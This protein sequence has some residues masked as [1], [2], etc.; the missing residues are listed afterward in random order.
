MWVIYIGQLMQSLGLVRPMNTEVAPSKL[1]RLLYWCFVIAAK[2]VSELWIIPPHV[3]RA[4]VMWLTNASSIC[5]GRTTA[6]DEYVGCDHLARAIETDDV[7][8]VLRLINKYP[9]II[10]KSWLGSTPLEL[11]V[12]TCALS[13]MEVLLACSD[14][15]A[16]EVLR[17]CHSVLAYQKLVAKGADPN[18]R[19]K[20][21]RRCVDVVALNEC[22]DV[23][24][25]MIRE[26]ARP[27]PTCFKV[28]RSRGQDDVAEKL[29][30]LIFEITLERRKFVSLLL[31]RS[32]DRLY[33]SSLVRD[34]I[35]EYLDV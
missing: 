2:A 8:Q 32:C 24:E 29:V 20:D 19:D 15:C 16:S 11:S 25:A 14:V 12:R 31:L 34:L 9:S 6:L 18:K 10:N 23:A 3:R 4:M 5:M 21:G 35:F 28:L 30:K 1:Q 27:S 22:M 7:D 13:S 33:S 26:G 17:C